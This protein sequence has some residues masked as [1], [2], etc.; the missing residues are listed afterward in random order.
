MASKIMEEIDEIMS[1]DSEELSANEQ[2]LLV[3]RLAKCVGKLE[4]LILLSE[5]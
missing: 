5:V 1:I 3:A 4:M 2:S